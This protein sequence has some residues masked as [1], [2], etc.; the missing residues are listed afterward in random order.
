MTS[1]R[2][3]RI[4]ALIACLATGLLPAAASATSGVGG[5]VSD[6]DT[7]L[8]LPQSTVTWNGTTSP[9]PTAV[10]DAQGRYAFYSLQ[11]NEHGSLGV[12]GPAGWDR[13]TVGDL[14]TPASGTITQSVALHRDW[15]SAAGGA[16]ASSNDES[17]GGACG[18][19][20]A[21]DADRTTG[22]SAGAS[23]PAGDPAAL[24]VALP[25]D[26]AL[27]HVMLDA[28][29]AC[30]HDAG[31]ALGKFRIETSADG[32]TWAPAAEGELGS[33]DRGV[34]HD[35][36]PTANTAGVRYLRVIA[37]TAQD[38]AATT[39]DLREVQAF[40]LRPDVAPSG[41]VSVEAPRNYI[42]SVVRFQAA[43]TD[44]DS[45]ITKYLWDFNGDGTWDQVT[46]GTNVAHVYAGPG[47]YHVIVGARDFQGTLGTTTIDLRISDPNA[48]LE[49]I[50]Q[51]K[52]LITFAAPDGID[53]LVRVACASK[54][55]FKA[56]MQLTA[57]TAR[58]LHLRRR[59][60]LK[61]K[62]STDG[63]GIGS[64]TLELPQSTIKRLR[65]AHLSKVRA[66][67]TATATD[68]EGRKSTA[69]R[70]VTFR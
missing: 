9:P 4:A 52:P 29:S 54:C 10:T 32:V 22:W 17:G 61:F 35:V 37:L 70:W 59:T 31:T 62:K 16:H 58:K 42:N 63:P 41:T 28:G 30:G 47:V 36:V 69:R 26:I 44:P 64:F 45:T 38:P 53:E 20:A 12:A 33:A 40:G 2:R 60:I 6:A 15:A 3:T 49:A 66:L 34:P 67:V 18:S 24:V 57:K 27:T 50:P 7:G 68:Q 5:Y 51:R 56:T 11:A 1:R 14:T 13:I 48:P 39:I 55:T 19:A 46:F 8:P 23:H 65:K 25:Q 21:I 43:F